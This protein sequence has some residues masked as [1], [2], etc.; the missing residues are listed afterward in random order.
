MCT[1]DEVTVAA[2]GT[3]Q[4]NSLLMQAQVA[5]ILRST[6]ACAE[7][8]TVCADSDPNDVHYGTAIPVY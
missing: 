2:A 4:L 8:H 3:W 1:G 7:Q 5:L 6:H